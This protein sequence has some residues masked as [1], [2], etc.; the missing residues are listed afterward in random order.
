MSLRISRQL[1]TRIEEHLEQVYPEEGAGMIVGLENASGRQ[2]L[3]L[4]PLPN[5]RQEAERHHR[6]LLSPQ[7]LLEAEVSAEARGLDI[8]GVF[9]SHPDHPARPSEFDRSWALPWYSYVIT[10]VRQGAA[11][12]SRSWRLLDDRSAF[13]EETIESDDHRPFLEK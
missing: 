13:S 4:I 5:Q 7:A 10:S 3:D 6:Y 2:A 9:H 1:L 11:R 12:E 8:I